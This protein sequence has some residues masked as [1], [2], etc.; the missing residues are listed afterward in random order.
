MKNMKISN[1]LLKCAKMINIDATIAD[2]GTDHAYIPIYLALKNKISY[3]LACDIRS[4]PLNNAKNNINKYKLNDII[5]TRLS[6]G[7][8]NI[9]ENEVN[10]IIIAGM[11]GNTIANILQN[12]K[13]K[14][15]NTKKFILQPMKY[16]NNLRKY[17]AE[18]GYE[19]LKEEA[20]TCSEKIYTVIVVSFTGIPYPLS[21]EEEYV[22]KL[23]EN[24]DEN[25]IAYI[26]KQIKNL[27]N[28]QKGAHCENLYEQEKY[29]GMIIE[30][31]NIFQK[32]KLDL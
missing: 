7:L 32:G 24:A 25:A 27:Q 16:E 18:T 26:K 1:R 4:G 17:L 6:N 19:I 22:G 5:E 30:K 11:G 29:Y 23:R 13:W 9:N 2:I 31:L 12:C 3:A 8:N 28:L 21:A 10:E 15:K 20:V 14:N